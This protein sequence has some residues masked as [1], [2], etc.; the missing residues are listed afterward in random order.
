MADKM[1]KTELILDEVLNE[2]G[3][4][5]E[6]WGGTDHD[7]AHHFSAFVEYI[8]NYAGWS[9]QM[10]DGFSWQKA[11]NRMVQVAALAV[12]AVEWIDRNRDC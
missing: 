4:Q 7:D 10:A 6:K 3:R 11:R 5:I 1:T 8:K 12:A 9:S 2:R